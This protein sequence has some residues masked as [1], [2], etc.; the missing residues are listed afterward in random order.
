LNGCKEDAS[1]E[2][3]DQKTRLNR[4]PEAAKR[5]HFLRKRGWICWLLTAPFFG[6]CMGVVILAGL[7]HWP[8]ANVPVYYFTV[9]PAFVWFGALAP[10]L[11]V[12]IFGVR[13]RWFLCGCLLWTIGFATSEEALEVVR[14]FAQRARGKFSAA[15]MGLLSYM[16]HNN[17]GTQIASIPLRIVTWN[18]QGGRRGGQQL[19]EQLA[20]LEPDIVL[21]QEF[22]PAGRLLKALKESGYF[23]EYDIKGRGRAILSRFPVSDL[24]LSAPRGKF[25]AW[26]VEIAP[27]I[28]VLCVNVHLSPLALKTQVVRGWSWKGI[29]S[30][31]SRT[32]SEL[33]ELRRMLDLYAGRSPIILAG[34]FN[35]PPHYPDLRRATAGLKDCFKANGFGWGKTA[36]VKLPAIRADMI[37][38]PKGATVY[39]ASAVPTNH[40]DHYMAL[41]EVSMPVSPTGPPE[42]DSHRTHMGESWDLVPALCPTKPFNAHAAVATWPCLCH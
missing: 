16:E 24:T 25:A 13:F 42:V 6:A 39:Y 17:P 38:V 28:R 20:E 33:E 31:I 2:S 26:Q 4:E 21:M 12:G 36:P 29:E 8:K 7:Y 18:V 15:R 5:P 22:H 30:A 10:F 32:Q 3:A 14:P 9:R 34:D 19:F 37:F 41:A 27:G 40:S 35:L 11:A 23:S 1:S